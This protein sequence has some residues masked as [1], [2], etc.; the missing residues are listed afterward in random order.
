MTP[1]SSAL[2]VRRT[3]LESFPQ[4]FRVQTQSSEALE[5]TEIYMV[6]PTMVVVVKADK[7]EITPVIPRGIATDY[8]D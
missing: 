3:V 5:V 4:E 1:E 6:G 7:A 2:A 8:L